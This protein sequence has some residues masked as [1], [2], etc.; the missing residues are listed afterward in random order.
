MHDAD[1]FAF[2]QRCG[3]YASPRLLLDDLLAVAGDFGFDHLILS[4]VPMGGQKLAPLVELNG[5]PEGWFERYVEKEYSGVDG[6]CLYSGATH[7]P[8]YWKDVPV[9]LA[10]T[11]G[12]RRVS[13]EATEFGIH[14]GFA[15]P[16]LSLNHWQSVVS[17]ASPARDCTLSEHEKAQLVSMATF[18]GAA[19]EAL[20]CPSDPEDALSDREKEVLLWHASGKTAWETG[21]I[22]KIA[23]STVRKHLAAAKEKYRVATTIQAVVQAIRRRVIHP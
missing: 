9:R 4:G 15:V 16:F 17:F 7:R 13:G 14:S 2:M 11:A 19:V 12:S 1:A 18:A 21:E 5:W 6:V 8:F 20:V 10:G 22:M 3:N 23:E